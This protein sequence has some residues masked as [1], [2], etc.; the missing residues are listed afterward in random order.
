[1]IEA[2]AEIVDAE[3][4]FAKYWERQF[5]D[6]R[7]SAFYSTANAMESH[8]L[9]LK[10]N[11]LE[12]LTERGELVHLAPDLP[13]LIRAL[14]LWRKD[15][16]ASATAFGDFVSDFVLR[17]GFSWRP[18]A[19]AVAELTRVG[20]NLADSLERFSN[21]RTITVAGKF[22]FDFPWHP[23]WGGDMHLEVRSTARIEYADSTFARTILKLDSV[24]LL[25]DLHRVWEVLP[26]SFAVD[27]VTSVGRR[28]HDIDSQVK[29]FSLMQ[30]HW[31]EHTYRIT[32]PV[33]PHISATGID[34][35]DGDLE[36]VYFRRELSRRIPPLRDSK[37]DFREPAGI[38]NVGVL[39]SLL[40]QR[41]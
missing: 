15:P 13:L 5:S 8:L 36:L 37:Y 19:D 1:V 16:V 26:Y 35:T 7:P 10:N 6:I 39:A 12:S 28:L 18:N 29:L 21:S 32:T 11:Y 34:F 23:Y 3:L 31:V 38:A 14:V 4:R 27:W 41:R 9:S 33:P 25:P 2:Q 40:W 20:P 24:G 30:L 17:H 22:H